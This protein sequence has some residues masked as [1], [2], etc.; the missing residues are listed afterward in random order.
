ML[1]TLPL[2]FALFSASTAAPVP[3]TNSSVNQISNT[4]NQGEDAI[5]A[6]SPQIQAVSK[7]HE[8]LHDLTNIVRSLEG[9]VVQ[10]LYGVG[11]ELTG[12][13][14]LTTHGVENKLGPVG[15]ELSGLFQL[16][17][18]TTSST[19]T[20]AEKIGVDAVIIV[21]GVLSVV[22]SAET[23]LQTLLKSLGNTI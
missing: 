5:R 9:T 13:V 3:D 18:S 4:I 22:D 20:L 8:P 16:I 14:D 12:V 6:L 19:L 11:N 17:D 21:N 7:S 10:V 1:P 23:Y 2:A 15:T